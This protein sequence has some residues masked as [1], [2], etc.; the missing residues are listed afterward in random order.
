MGVIVKYRQ[1]NDEKLP[2]QLFLK[3]ENY[4][5]NYPIVY[6]IEQIKS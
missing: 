4:M 5:L 1:S 2:Q 6:V 3:K